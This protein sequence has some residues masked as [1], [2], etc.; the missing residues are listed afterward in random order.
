MCFRVGTVQLHVHVHLEKICHRYQTNALWYYYSV[1]AMA[2]HN[3]D[4]NYGLHLTPHRWWFSSC[5]RTKPT[6]AFYN[7]L[8][9]K[10]QEYVIQSI[11]SSLQSK[12]CHTF[13]SITRQVLSIQED[14]YQA[15][16]TKQSKRYKENYRKVKVNDKTGN[17]PSKIRIFAIWA[18]D[19][20]SQASCQESLMSD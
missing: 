10:H 8:Q 20:K 11:F 16:I 7:L 2:S 3:S 9:S 12:A 17:Q 15:L 6:L 13:E 19:T 5:L 18:K 14:P 4:R 1:S